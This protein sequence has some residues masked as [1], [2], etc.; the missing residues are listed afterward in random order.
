ML[1]QTNALTCVSFRKE[2]IECLSSIDQ[3]LFYSMNSRVFIRTNS[4][5]PAIPLSFE[6]T[7]GERPD[8]SGTGINCRTYEPL[9]LLEPED[10]TMER[11]G[12][13]AVCSS[14]VVSEEPEDALCL[15]NRIFAAAFLDDAMDRQLRLAAARCRKKKGSRA[16]CKSVR[17]FLKFKIVEEA[18]HGFLC[19]GTELSRRHVGE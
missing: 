8:A 4:D 11:E 13:C 12:I 7:S 17:R 3:L 14:V 16:L 2:H 18:L 6:C 10:R 9:L 15:R 19:L 1:E 5:K